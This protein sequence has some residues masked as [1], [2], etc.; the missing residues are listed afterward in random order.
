MKLDHPLRSDNHKELRRRV[1]QFFHSSFK[2]PRTSN[3]VFVCGGNS[4]DHMRQRFNA[5]TRQLEL[6]YLF[7]QPEF[8]MDNIFSH[9][10]PKQFDIADFE[11]IIGNLS[12]AIVIFPEAAGSFAETGYFSANE[13]LSKKSILV[14]DS[15]YQNTDSFISLGPAKKIGENSDYHPNI[16]LNYSS[17]DFHIILDRLSRIKIG[18]YY[19][20][21]QW[22]IISDLSEHELFCLIYE[23]VR[24][25]NI[26]TIKD[27]EF[28]LRALSSSHVSVPRIHQISSILVGSGMLTEVGDYGH[29]KAT[30]GTVDLLKVVEGSVSERNEL[31]LTMAGVYQNSDME[32]RDLAEM[33]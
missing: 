27:I 9:A 20:R 21:M 19:R 24:F 1:V 13:N 16:Q 33:A 11:T 30:N 14:M 18:K 29:L 2:A 17:P 5:F 6:P 22:R 8:A 4:S 31:K 3:I 7:F 10:F 25:L 23:I 26:L 32:F 28:F 12:H 15:S